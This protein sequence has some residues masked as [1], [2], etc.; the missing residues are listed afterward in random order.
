MI[1]SNVELNEMIKNCKTSQELQ[2]LQIDCA[3]EVYGTIT[4]SQ[5]LKILKAKQKLEEKE[6]GRKR[7]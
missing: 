1:I 7:K 5:A 6:R 2:Q 4:D 3:N